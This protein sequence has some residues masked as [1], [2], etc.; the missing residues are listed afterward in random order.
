MPLSHHTVISGSKFNYSPISTLI[1]LFFILVKVS[2]KSELT[3]KGEI[4]LKANHN[5]SAQGKF[6]EQIYSITI[7]FSLIIMLGRLNWVSVQLYER[8]NILDMSNNPK[9]KYL[10]LKQFIFYTVYKSVINSSK[11]LK[12]IYLNNINVSLY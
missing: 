9:I 4:N 2:P 12:C 3:R 10:T 6:L 8:M 7:M 1:K 11:S 5:S